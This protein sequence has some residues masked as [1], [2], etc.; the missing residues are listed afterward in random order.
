MKILYSVIAKNG[1]MLILTNGETILDH[2][3]IGRFQTFNRISRTL[4]FWRE[5]YGFFIEIADCHI[6]L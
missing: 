1:A 2:K 6:K 4:D 5:K 3:K